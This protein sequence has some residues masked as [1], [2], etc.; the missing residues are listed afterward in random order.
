M[1]KRFTLGMVLIC[2]AAWMQIAL[3]QAP[4]A[5]TKLTAN[6]VKTNPQS[7]EL[8]WMGV[9]SPVA[10]KIFYK[11]YRS[12]DDSAHFA[13]QAAKGS[14]G[15]QDKGVSVGHTY[16]YQVTAVGVVHDTSMTEGKPSNIAWAKLLA[17]IGKGR[18]VISGTVTDS[19]AGT[20]LA[21]AMVMFFRHVPSSWEVP[22][23]LTDSLGRYTATLDTGAYFVF[24]QATKFPYDAM[25]NMAPPYRSKWYKDAYEPAKATSVKAD[26]PASVANFKLVRFSVPV[27]V[28]LRGTVKDTA[29]KAIAGADV[30]F[31]RTPQELQSKAAVD[32]DADK[33]E[34][35]DLDD[36]GHL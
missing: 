33:S 22:T 16:F 14:P 13:Y 35:C 23:V 20:P 29:G 25:M 6:V 30:V 7:V 28:T 27:F 1:V 36:F 19:A 8:T 26:S 21:H 24:A 15:Y 17:E 12:V 34:D 18:G 32:D 4:P 11:V 10:G 31:G 5:P 2:M 9:H 3:A